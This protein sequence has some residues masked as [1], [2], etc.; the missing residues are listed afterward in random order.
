[1]SLVCLD[2]HILIWG[3]RGIA[4]AGQEPMIQRAKALL[5]ELD[6]DN[7]EILVPSVVVG[8]FLAG[9]PKVQHTELLNVL[10]RRFQIPPFDVRAAVVAAGLWRDFAERSPTLREQLRSDFPAVEKAKLKADVQILAIA[11]ARKAEVL[12]THDGALKTVASGLI[13]VRELPPAPPVQQE[14]IP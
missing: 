14:F 3:I 11:L 9:V 5:D 2:N 7:A 4:T 1:M 12:Y 13:A 6:K 8:E 10:N